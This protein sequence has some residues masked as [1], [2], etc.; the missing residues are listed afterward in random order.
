MKGEDYIDQSPWPFTWKGSVE[1]ALKRMDRVQNIQMQFPWMQVPLPKPPG[2]SPKV[3][4]LIVSVCEYNDETT[5]LTVLSYWNKKRYANKHGYE[6]DFHKKG[7]LSN[8]PFRK[9]FQEPEKNR[10]PAWSKSNP[11][12]SI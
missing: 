9:L 2:G 8:D 6:V 12:M 5:P 11:A 1:T 7:P 10:P 4:I 3:K